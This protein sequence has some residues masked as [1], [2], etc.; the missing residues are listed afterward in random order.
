MEVIHKVLVM[1]GKRTGEGEKR[2]THTSCGGTKALWGKERG[3]K[4]LT[5]IGVVHRRR[6]K[7]ADLYPFPLIQ[8]MES[9][10]KRKK[11]E[12]NRCF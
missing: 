10:K 5:F 3:G 11:K 4:K 7:S 9:Y 12:V 1:K 8:K 2:H 6:E